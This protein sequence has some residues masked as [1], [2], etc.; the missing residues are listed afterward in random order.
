MAQPP[1]IPLVVYDFMF[2]LTYER[3]LQFTLT[4]IAATP[5]YESFMSNVAP[6]VAI[7]PKIHSYC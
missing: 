6:D 4:T 7:I 3:E 1:L 5:L 2:M